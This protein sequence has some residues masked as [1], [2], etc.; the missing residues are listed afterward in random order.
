M[1]WRLV[2]APRTSDTTGDGSRWRACPWSGN[3]CGGMRR[4]L[5]CSV[6][7]AVLL[8]AAAAQGRTCRSCYEIGASARSVNPAPD[9]SFDGKPVFLGG[10]GLG[11]PPISAGR[12][13]T[14]VLRGGVAV[15]AMTI[16]VPGGATWAIADVEEQGWPIALKD[17][18]YGLAD[19]RLAVARATGGAIRASAVTIQSDHTHS[20]PDLMG[21]WGGVPLAY[22]KFV[23]ERTLQAITTAY[24][25]RRLGRL[26]YGTAEGRDLLSN[27]FDYDAANKGLDSQV[28]VLQARTRAGRPFATLLNFS[29]HATV[30]GPDTTKVSGDWVEAANRQLRRAFGGRVLTVVGTLGRTQPADR[31]CPDPTLS[32]DAKRLCALD[33]YAARVVGRARA[34]A[35]SERRLSRAAAVVARSYLVR[36]VATSAF[37][38]GLN[39][40]GSPLGAPLDRSLQSPWETGPVIGTSTGSVRIGDLLVSAIPG[41]AYPQIAERIRQLVPARGWLTA[42]LAN[43]QLGYLIYPYAAYPEPIRRTF[44]D[45]RGD[46]ISP[47][48]NDNYAFNASHSLGARVTCSLLRGAGE[49]FGRGARYRDADGGCGPFANDALAGAGADV[50][51]GG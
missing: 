26:W 41:E 9:G 19:L 5:A 4:L 36:D 16:G 27:Q 11:S 24:A 13:A 42:G 1:A 31:G 14:G 49:V 46:Q 34:A 45:Q 43:D 48:D 33:R 25:Q 40:A 6:V 23:F 22:R 47:I 28:R 30:L 8:P 3:L 7:A 38:L 35:K 18:P 10:Y 32:G 2:A 17:G 44:F 29:A 12:R 37:V 15:R 20:G 51:P 39:I 50:R 21:V